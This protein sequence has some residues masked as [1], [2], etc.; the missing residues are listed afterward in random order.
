MCAYAV[1][2]GL[3]R[4]SATDGHVETCRQA[5]P[6]GGSGEQLECVQVKGPHDAEMA[7]IQGGDLP[8]SQ[9]LGECD[10]AGVDATKAEVGVGPHQ[11]GDAFPVGTGERLDAQVAYCDGAVEVGFRLAAEL[12]VNQPARLSNNQGRGDERPRVALEERPATLVVGSASSAAASMTLVSTGRLSGRSPRR[13]CPHP[14]RHVGRW[15]I[16]RG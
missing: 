15:S 1:W 14:L 2:D 10:K 11:V 3:H 9:T 7:T 4:P 13:A 6:A 12:A 16:G 8:R 5:A